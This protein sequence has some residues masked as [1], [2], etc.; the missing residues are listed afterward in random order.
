MGIGGEA[1]LKNNV[2]ELQN[3]LGENRLWS[4]RELMNTLVSSRGDK[5]HHW[6]ASWL[7]SGKGST[8]SHPHHP[9]GEMLTSE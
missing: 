7:A 6:V 8:H 3:V 9:T 2:S 1:S 4:K 5:E